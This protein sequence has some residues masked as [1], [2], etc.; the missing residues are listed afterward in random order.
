MSAHIRSTAGGLEQVRG[1]GRHAPAR[2]RQLLLR[3][4]ERFRSRPRRT[5]SAPASASAWAI[6]R[7]GRGS[8]GDEGA[9][10]FKRNLSS[11]LTAGPPVV[12]RSHRQRWRWPS[13]KHS[14][15]TSRPT[16]VSTIRWRRC[17]IGLAGPSASFCSARSRRR[18]QSRFA[19]ARPA[20]P[21]PRQP[22]VF[23][24]PSALACARVRSPRDTR[25]SRAPPRPSPPARRTPS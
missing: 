5:R 8:P 4:P 13:R 16:S 12:C 19:A 9:A 10:S 11:T 20:A 14:I 23:V 21:G 22:P 3:L 17:R 18:L 24:S 2:C 7:P 25:C 6:A 15:G 1:D